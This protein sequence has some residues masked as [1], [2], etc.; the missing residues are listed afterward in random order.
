[1]CYPFSIFLFCCPSPEVHVVWNGCV[2][3]YCALMLVQYHL[4]IDD[5]EDSPLVF[6]VLQT[7]WREYLD[8]AT[9]N[10]FQGVI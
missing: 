3:T 2:V 7:I 6:F 8:L 10:R 5:N 4:N 9:W 1:M